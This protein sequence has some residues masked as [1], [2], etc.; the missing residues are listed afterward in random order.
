MGEINLNA[1]SL[2]ELKQLQ[3]RISKTI[4][5]FE[6]RQKAEARAKLEAV[7]KEMG[8]SLAQFGA[9]EVKAARAPAVAKYCNPED[10]S[11][12][13]SGRGR[14]PL[15]FIAAVKNGKTPDDMAIKG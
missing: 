2:N 15:W 8:Y 14:K 10:A 7:A 13:W 1:L 4:D 3:K 12:T 11:M 9:A 5:T 6:D